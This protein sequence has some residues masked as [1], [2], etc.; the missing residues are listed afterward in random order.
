M[1]RAAL[2]QLTSSDD[3]GENLS[4]FKVVNRWGQLPSREW[5]GHF[6]ACAVLG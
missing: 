4:N 2:L 6:N 3:P 5:M 1:T